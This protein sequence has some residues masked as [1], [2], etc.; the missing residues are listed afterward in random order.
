MN[1]KKYIIFILFVSIIFNV[2]AQQKQLKS[3]HQAQ[4]EFYN[5]LGLKTIYE[6][7]SINNFS[8]IYKTTSDTNCNLQKIVFGYHPYWMG[9]SYLNYQWNLLSDLCY[10]SYE[11]NPVTGDPVTTHDWLTADAVDSAQANNVR[12][13]LCV[14]L[15]SSH[16]IFFGNPTAQQ[17]LI[18]NLISLVQQ[19]NA[20]GINLD[21]EAV[22]W[23]QSTY[24]NQFIVNICEQFHDSIPGS[25]ISIAMP[26]VDWSE[27]YNIEMI[28]DHIDIFMIMAYD[29]YWNGSSQAGPVS[30][31][32]ALVP[33]YDFNLS[34]TISYYYSKGMP[35]SKF[36]LGLPYYGRQWHTA[37]NTVPSTTI[38]SGTA[39]TYAQ[40]KNNSSGNY[41]YENKHWDNKSFSN[42]Y[43]FQ[44]NDKWFQ[45]FVE[46]DYGLAERYDIVNQRGL[47]G[48]GIWALGYDDGYTKLWDV[49]NDKFTDYRIPAC[50]DTI[51]DTGGP[52][53][54]HYNNE[55]YFFTIAPENVEKLSLIFSSFNLEAGYDSLWIFDGSDTLAP[56]IGGYSGTNSPDTIFAS[57]S[58]LTIKFHSDNATT[59][60]GWEA[61]YDCLDHLNIEEQASA[62]L[63]TIYPNPATN[64]FPIRV[65]FASHISDY[66]FQDSP[67]KIEIFDIFGKKVKEIIIPKDEI[68]FT[69][70]TEDMEKGLYFVKVFSGKEYYSTGKVIIQ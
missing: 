31:L 48:I 14:T 36:V 21:F 56:L 34:K 35:A 43:A 54:D 58:S 64:K 13:H 6:F 24:L 67:N 2:H 5:K 17:N 32:Y 8:G 33:G 51:F 68:N 12:T 30:P 46:E 25:I 1:I 39:L 27:I 49:I 29:Y 53:W 55:D 7:D 18:N 50:R 57:G 42:Y 61:I 23:S 9:S 70:N 37:S 69:V 47:S 66:K 28:K 3:I 15:F 26:A 65:C 11:V 52:A 45:C 59:S 44:S 4:S 63:L 40:I 22:S 16:S 41:S 60:S 20:N 62:K 38:G 10:F 19:R